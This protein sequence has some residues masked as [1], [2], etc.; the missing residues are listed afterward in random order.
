M[1][2]LNGTVKSQTW[3]RLN[4]LLAPYTVPI[5]GLSLV[6]LQHLAWCLV[7]N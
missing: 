7:Q 5:T 2:L 1:R 6:S 4:L 3:V